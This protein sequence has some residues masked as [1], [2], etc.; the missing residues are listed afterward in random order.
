MAMPITIPLIVSVAAGA[1]NVNIL[2]GIPQRVLSEPSAV[3]LA[4]SR[5]VV[6]IT[7]GFEI[8]NEISIPRGSAVNINAVNGTLPRYDTDNV[9]RFLGDTTQELA[10]FVSNTNAAAKEIRVQMRITAAEDLQFLPAN[11]S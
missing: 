1:L 2:A 5:E 8:G 10:L 9:G 7:I 6:E 11:V 4:V 3:D